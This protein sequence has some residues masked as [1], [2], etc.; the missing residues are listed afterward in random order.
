MQ[1]SSVRNG[2]GVD[3]KIHCKRCCNQLN[4]DGTHVGHEINVLRRARKAIVGAGERTAHHVGNAEIVKQSG[5]AGDHE[6]RIGEHRSVS[7][8]SRV[9]AE[10]ADHQLGLNPSRR[11]A[12]RQFFGCC[13]RM[14]ATD[15]QQCKLPHRMS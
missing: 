6:K 3:I 1:A 10:S 9:P 15:I 4:M 13:F 7:R 12:E 11:E 8:F 5:Q 2:F 14:S